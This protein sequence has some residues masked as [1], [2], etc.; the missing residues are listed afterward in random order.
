M[1]S[2]AGDGTPRGTAPGTVCG[3]DLQ[4]CTLHKARM[5]RRGVRVLSGV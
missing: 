4:I 3:L 5:P 2:L 1:E